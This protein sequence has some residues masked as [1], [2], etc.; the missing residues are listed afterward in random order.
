MIGEKPRS[1]RA[2]RLAPGSSNHS[3]VPAAAQ[4]SAPSREPRAPRAERTSSRAS[5]VRVAQ[6]FSKRLRPS[7][8]SQLR[9]P[10]SPQVPALHAPGPAGRR[11]GR[12][13]PAARRRSSR[14]PSAADSRLEGLALT[15]PG[16]YPGRAPSGR[17]ELD[18]GGYEVADLHKTRRTYLSQRIFALE[19]QEGPTSPLRSS[20]A[21]L[22]GF[23]SDRPPPPC[24]GFRHPSSSPGWPATWRSSSAPERVTE[25]PQ[26][27][28]PGDSAAAGMIKNARCAY[29]DHVKTPPTVWSRHGPPPGRPTSPT[30]ATGLVEPGA[31]RHRWWV[32]GH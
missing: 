29:A 22:E 2:S 10:V 16:L 24:R 31:D 5:G 14:A 17:Y 18:E 19:P 1:R 6:P 30:G 11:S 7:K 23:G 9:V 3:S 4:S 26:M 15:Y 12:P 8:G 21:P 27:C 28:T 25:R 32:Q 20:D 13:D